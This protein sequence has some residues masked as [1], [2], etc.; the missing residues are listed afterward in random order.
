MVLYAKELGTI[1]DLGG[2]DVFVV[3]VG[4]PEDGE[5]RPPFGVGDGYWAL[6]FAGL[7]E[8]LP[9]VTMESVVPSG[10]CFG[11]LAHNSGKSS[12]Y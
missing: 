2:L 11:L 5:S 9:V 7:A 8:T 4:S 12:K 10:G 1:G 6:V 3:G